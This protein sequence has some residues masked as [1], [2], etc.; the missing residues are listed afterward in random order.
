MTGVFVGVCSGGTVDEGERQHG[1]EEQIAHSL[2]TGESRIKKT[3]SGSVICG[4][5]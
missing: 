5:Q 4:A 1:Q 3:K 2:E